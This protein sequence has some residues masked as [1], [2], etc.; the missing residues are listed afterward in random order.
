MS[1]CNPCSAGLGRQVKTYG[2]GASDDVVSTQDEKALVHEGTDL[3]I[4]KDLRGGND[5][6]EVKPGLALDHGEVRGLERVQGLPR[7]DQVDEVW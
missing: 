7:A 6:V 1:P 4:G 3:G 5:R 2:A